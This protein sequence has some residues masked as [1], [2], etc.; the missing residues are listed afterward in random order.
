MW[1]RTV[2]NYQVRHL[3]AAT[4]IGIH[5]PLPRPTHRD[6]AALTRLACAAST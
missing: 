3:S 2:M 4:Q 5:I 1:M 6:W